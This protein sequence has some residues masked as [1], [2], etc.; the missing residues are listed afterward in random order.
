MLAGI[1]LAIM[2][3]NFVSIGVI[4]GLNQALH[5]YV[6]PS[7]QMNQI[8]NKVYLNRARVMN[9]LLMV[10]SSILIVFAPSLFNFIGIDP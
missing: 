10:P 4:Y 2:Y 7:L 1:G 3:I 6:E 9:L 5:L 8:L